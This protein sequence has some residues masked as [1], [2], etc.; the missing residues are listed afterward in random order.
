MST[1]PAPLLDSALGLYTDAARASSARVIRAYSTSFGMA[2]RLFDRRYRADV[3]SIYG[4]VRIADE[5]V[6]GAAAEAGLDLRQQRELLDELERETA[7]AIE[8]GYSTN[9]V[10][11]AFAVTAR[12]CGIEDAIISPFFASMR[13]DL[14]PAP[15][16]DYELKEYIYGSAEVVGLMCLRVFLRDQAVEAS[17][18]AEL[19]QGA[20]R[21]GAAFQK[22][23]FLRDL[24]A[25]WHE[26]GRNYF[27]GID[28]D[29]LT[30]QQKAALRADIDDDLDA[31]A[32][33]VPKLPDGS[34]PAVAAALALFRELSA[35]L[36]A[37]PAAEL[38]TR[39]VRVPTPRKL[40][41][42]ARAKIGALP[43][44]TS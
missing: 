37:T 42:V 35:R 13:R 1:R 18:R 19:K 8:R 3:E 25:D 14:S 36:R 4:L 10:V 31:A 32:A 24:A 23:N 17:D 39:R 44:S 29:R 20:R 6:D 15:L 9:V 34:R 21:L 11:H 16:T 40:A 33:V 43:G 28:P 27:P 41:I 12:S 2:C 5:V 7:R 26:L 30:E 38:T 22:I